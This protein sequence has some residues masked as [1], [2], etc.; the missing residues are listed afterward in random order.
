MSLKLNSGD[1]LGQLSQK[2]VDSSVPSKNDH[3]IR[4][5]NAYGTSHHSRHSASQRTAS[6]DGYSFGNPYG[7]PST[8]GETKRSTT[9]AQRL[10][11]NA[12][13]FSSGQSSHL[14]D[15]LLQHSFS[16]DLQFKH[17]DVQQNLDAVASGVGY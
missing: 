3:H 10:E 7:H 5:H 13:I 12:Q 8:V 15:R 6:Q 4:H 11:V 17:L 14:E 2:Q 16:P 1:L 9:E